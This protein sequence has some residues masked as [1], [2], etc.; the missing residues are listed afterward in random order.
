M[1]DTLVRV[2]RGS[3]NPRKFSAVLATFLVACFGYL[4][5]TTP[6]AYAASAS[7][8]GDT[9]VYQG[10]SFTK[11]T[12]DNTPTQIESSSAIYQYIDESKNPNL[13]YFIYFD[14]DVATP[15]SEKEASYIRYT[16]NPPNDSTQPNRYVNPTE[17][18]TITIQPA[19]DS[20][21][22]GITGEAS[23]C[24]IGASVSWLVCGVAGWIADTVDVVYGWLAAFLTVQ[25]LTSENSSSLYNLWNIVR[26]FANVAFV[27]GFL[28][29]IYS[30]LAGGGF[31]GY[32]IRKIL[33]RVV[34]AAILINISF[35]I[36]SIAIDISNIAGV[37]LQDLLINI[38]ENAVAVGEND[39]VGWGEMA[40][41]VLS[42]GTIGTIAFLSAAGA[43]GS[44]SALAFMLVIVLIT[45]V[46]SLLVAF[47]IL[48]A[49][50]AILIILVILSPLAFAAFILPNTEKWFE[51]WRSIFTTLLLLF[52][53]F[54]LLFG[55]SQ[56]A[57]AAIIQNAPKDGPTLAIM[58]FGMAVQIVPLVIT[59][60]LIQFS[61][62]LIGRI[63]GVVNNSEKGIAD[64]S[65]NWARDRAEMRKQHNLQKNPAEANRFNMARRG[66]QRMYAKDLARKQ[67]LEK[68]KQDAE[69]LAHDKE[70]GN[71]RIANSRVGQALGMPERLEKSS[72]SYWDKEYRGAKTRHD[73][74]EA[75]HKAAFDEQF[76]S[77]SSAFNPELYQARANA[78]KYA[79]ASKL[80]DGSFD[81]D[82]KEL[83]AGESQE[84]LRRIENDQV[85]KAIE[86]SLGNLS[87]KLQVQNIELSAESERGS[88]ADVQLKSQITQAYSANDVTINGKSIREYAAGIDRDFGQQRVTAAAKAAQTKELMTNTENFQNTLPFDISSNPDK[89]FELARTTQLTS[90]KIAY[91]RLLAAMGTPGHDRLDKLLNE[92]T[93]PS[94]YPADPT[95]RAK[96][97]SDMKDYR[98]I[99]ATD[100]NFTTAGRDFEVWARNEQKADTD[101]NGNTFF[102]TYNS[103]ADATN[104]LGIWSEISAQRWARMGK[105]KQEQSL[106]LLQ[107]QNPDGLRDIARR[108]T[109]DKT[110]LSQLKGKPH[111]WIMNA[112]EGK[113]LDD[114]R[115]DTPSDSGE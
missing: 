97:E 55:G 104:T 6:T 59:P 40:T 54:S 9:I 29:V 113:P 51:R 74:S 47:I 18:K 49:R 39:N 2:P 98:E 106:E 17:V 52:P 19:S 44:F 86:S 46:F 65:K 83:Q 64:R 92:Y 36:C 16:L 58:L 100:S 15:Q 101:A 31:N 53:I 85:R 93:A 110:A 5:A 82:M 33:P 57:G 105:I 112:A 81:A 67:R 48:A 103:F 27:I 108:V 79:N 32:E 38:R 41:Y 87:T 21:T 43:A 77:S 107:A 26:N 109:E 73:A 66:A 50:Q 60:L 42:G 68:Y 25:P 71:G 30:Y 72:Y 7:W 28:V 76:D 69:T 102:R 94:S 114:P 88:S 34:L 78:F 3:Y 13:A 11:T 4:F 12:A 90:E 56:L 115:E 23:S 1:W 91:S 99:M 14:T 22:S 37:S 70:F 8:E 111:R 63:A 95:A 24:N 75:H 96:F 35:W 20:D 80:A 45:V 61:G 10:K 62:G 84:V 89:L